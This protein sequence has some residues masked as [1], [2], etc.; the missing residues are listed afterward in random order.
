MKIGIID[1]DLLGRQ[2]HRFPNLA[3]M[4]ISGYYKASGCEVKLVS[5]DSV[6][7]DAFFPEKFDKIFLS[8]V[9]T[10]TQVPEFIFKMDNLEYGGTGFFFDLAPSLPNEIE[11]HFPD[12]HLYDNYLNYELKKVNRKKKWFRYY[13]DYSIGFTTRGCFRHC[14]FCVNRNENKVRVHSPVSEFLDKKR[15]KIC[16][17]DD[18]VFGYLRWSE[19]FD[20]L[21][22]ANKPVQYNLGLD[23]RL[24]TEKKAEYLSKIKY[25]S[26]MTF[27][28]DNYQDK[29][30]IVKKI[31]IFKKVMP[32]AIP[33]LFVL[34]AFDRNDK[35]DLE[36]W[37]R[38]VV[39]L[40]ERLKV[41]MKYRCVP[42]IMRFIK[43]KECPPV[44][45]P[46]YEAVNSFGAPIIF[47]KKTFLEYA[48]P[49]STGKGRMKGIVKFVREY[50]Q[51]ADK[52]FNLRYG[53]I[54]EEV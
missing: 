19:V 33:R 45:Y 36:F 35:Y 5:Y 11:H 37:E 28:F 27:A 51:I 13:F 2:N 31:Q 43:W 53:E 15:K 14:Q 48:T 40:F 47:K 20:Q 16:L 17:L 12:Y 54:N 42:Y 41:L 23:I 49:S 26:F 18:N 25:D 39:E 30:V 1:A 6:H 52:Y 4:K 34:I 7:S 21:I 50:P 3:L 29:D 38:D 44:F 22:E 9:F 32:N 24:L 8:K 46:V 10:E